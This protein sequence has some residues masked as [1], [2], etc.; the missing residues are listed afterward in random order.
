MVVVINKSALLNTWL[1]SLKDKVY[2]KR[3][4]KIEGK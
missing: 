4:S 2:N 3:N 1:I